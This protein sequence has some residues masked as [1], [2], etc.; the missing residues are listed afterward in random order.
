MVLLNKVALSSFGF[1]CPNALLLFQCALCAA[2]VQGCGLVGL[3]KLEPWSA[4]ITKIWFPVNL[5]FVAMI[6]TSF[7]SLQA[8]GVRP[9]HCSPCLGLKLTS[10]AGWLDVAASDN[11]LLPLCNKQRPDTACSHAQ[12]PTATVLKNLSN[13]FTIIGD[14]Y[15]YNKVYNKGVW[16]AL[17]L[18]GLSALCAGVTDLSFSLTG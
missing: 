6:G 7:Y 13:L 3:I 2:L 17:G 5:I 8:L 14:Y 16:A 1:Q 18:M 4:A 10:L 11:K 12:V 15:L 9:M